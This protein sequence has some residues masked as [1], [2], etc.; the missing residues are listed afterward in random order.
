MWAI[1]YSAN[2]PKQLWA[3]VDRTDK[4]NSGNTAYCNSFLGDV[5]R[6]NDF[7]ASI[8]FAHDSKPCSFSNLDSVHELAS[9]FTIYRG[10][11]RKWNY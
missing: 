1:K 9:D 11:K 8:S 3:A 4:Y 7:F 2:T 5:N 6:V 10:R